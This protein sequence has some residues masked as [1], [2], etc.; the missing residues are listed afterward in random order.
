MGASYGALAAH[1]GLWEVAV[2]TAGDVLTRM[3]LVPRVLEAR[4]L[5][6]TPGMIR[7]VDDVGDHRFA[8]IL[9]VI[10][11]DEVRHVRTGSE[12][13]RYV[14]RA[15]GLDSDMT[16]DRILRKYMADLN[17]TVSGPFQTDARIKAGFSRTEMDN[18]KHEVY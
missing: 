2:Y 13:F 6:V 12:W 18:L 5:D 10:F 14:C 7:R 3:A 11:R 9:R 16:F 1:N 17:A 4:G 15:R 8:D